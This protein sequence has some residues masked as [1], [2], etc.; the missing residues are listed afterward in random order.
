M[1]SSTHISSGKRKD[2]TAKALHAM[3]MNPTNGR[4]AVVHVWTPW[5]VP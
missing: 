3:S 4:A 2:C 5:I 1:V